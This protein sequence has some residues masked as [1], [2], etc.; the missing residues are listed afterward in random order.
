TVLK[1]LRGMADAEYARVSAANKVSVYASYPFY[2]YFALFGERKFIDEPVDRFLRDRWSLPIWRRFAQQL[3]NGDRLDATFLK[4]RK[5]RMRIWELSPGTYQLREG[6]DA[7]DDEQFDAAPATRALA[8]I[9]GSFVDL[10]L[11][12]RQVHLVELKQLAARPIPKAL[13]DLAVGDG[14]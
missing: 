2:S 8:L 1:F 14:D 6:A 12:P 5:V 9:R 7:N 13:P 3:P 4:Q 11:P 10:E